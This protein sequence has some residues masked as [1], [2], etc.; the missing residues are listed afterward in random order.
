MKKKEEKNVFF[1]LQKYGKNLNFSLGLIS[2]K[3]SEIFSTYLLIPVNSICVL[4]FCQTGSTN[5]ID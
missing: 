1:I 2:E 4:R 3:C 5:D